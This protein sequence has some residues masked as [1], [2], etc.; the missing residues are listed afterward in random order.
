MS[1]LNHR[2]FNL[3][4]PTID[5][6]YDG[7]LS[8]PRRTF[9]WIKWIYA[10]LSIEHRQ[11]LDSNVLPPSIP[12]LDSEIA[13]LTVFSNEFNKYKMKC[14]FNRSLQPHSQQD[15][16]D[17]RD[18]SNYRYDL[19][20]QRKEA[21]VLLKTISDTSIATKTLISDSTGD[22]I[23]TI[24]QSFASHKDGQIAQVRL[25]LRAVA[26]QFGGNP[27][28]VRDSIDAD[29]DFIKSSRNRREVALMI[30]EFSHIRLEQ[31]EHF[32]LNAKNPV[33]K[34]LRV[35]ITSADAI[36]FM[37]VRLP[38]KFYELFELR[39][40]LDTMP[41]T[42]PWGTIEEMLLFEI[43]SHTI[44]R[45]EMK[46]IEWRDD[47]EPKVNELTSQYANPPSF[48]KVNAANASISNTIDMSNFQFNDP[49][50]ASSTLLS[51]FNAFPTDPLK[52]QTP[53]C[54]YWNGTVCAFKGAHPCNRR[55]QDGVDQ[56]PWAQLKANI[57]M[58]TNTL[59]QSDYQDFLEFQ[60]AKRQKLSNTGSQLMITNDSSH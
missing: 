10:S 45:D 38:N 42:T 2:R 54:T 20:E 46:E 34:P 15:L 47:P 24:M 59:N 21:L 22:T 13:A 44:T 6:R 41:E 51:V 29:F 49:P 28:A 27:V 16:D 53:A 35:P 7:S 43:Q 36:K 37:R 48:T 58:P 52:N 3:Y 32:E 26:N 33:P 23:K 57:Q 18:V 14:I 12:E 17:Q 9:Q 1:S 31:L 50:N 11:M 40:L 60:C 25:T 39:K 5:G 56:R 19:A 30:A 55:H 8:D 4:D